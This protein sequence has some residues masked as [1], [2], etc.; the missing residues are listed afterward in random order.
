MR[1]RG[2]RGGAYAWGL[3]TGIVGG[4][5][6]DPGPSCQLEFTQLSVP[7]HA[8]A[9]LQLPFIAHLQLLSGY[10]NI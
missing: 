2:K 4:D 1:H 9:K 7:S 10:N 8:A 5:K 3:A 6:F